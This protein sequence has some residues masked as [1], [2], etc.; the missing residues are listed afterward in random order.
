MFRRI[1]P[2]LL[3]LLMLCVSCGLAEENKAAASG[4]RDADYSRA[5][6]ENYVD[7][8]WK[9]TDPGQQITTVDFRE[10]LSGLISRLALDRLDWF[11]DKVT[12]FQ[13]P[14][15]RGQA[16]T[17]AWYA[18]VCVGA[19]GYTDT[20]HNYSADDPDFWNTEGMSMD[21]LFPE[22]FQPN[23]IMT[24]MSTWDNEFIAS[25]LWNQWHLSPYS[26]KM[27]FDFDKAAVSM[28]NADPCTA[29]EA[30]CAVT[31]LYD[32]A[33]NIQYTFD[34]AAYLERGGNTD[35]E[36]ALLQAADIRRTAIR[37]SRNEI[38][39]TGATYYVSPFG[40]NQNDGKSPENAWATPQYAFSRGLNAGDAVLLERGGEWVVQA[41]GENGST[42]FALLVPEGV[43]VGAYGEGAK[44][45]IRGDIPSESNDPSFWVL[46]DEREGARI[47]KAAHDL[48]DINVIVLN[49]GEV[50]AEKV[51]PCFNGTD[52]CSED[53][54]PFVP[55]NALAEN[56]TFCC[57][58]DLEGNATNVSNR[59]LSGPLYL[60]CDEGNPAEVWE[61]IAVPQCVF[62]V[63]LGKDRTVYDLDIRYFTGGGV[64]MVDEV[65]LQSGTLVNCEISWC[66]GMVAEYQFKNSPIAYAYCGGC[67]VQVTGNNTVVRGCYIHDCGPMAL[68]L[69]I[70]GFDEK[71]KEYR[72][73]NVLLTGN[74][75]ERSGPDHFAEFAKM[76]V[77]GSHGVI[78]NYV[79]EDNMSFFSGMGWITGLI[80][81]CEKGR[82]APGLFRS[83]VEN[84]MGPA[85][86]EGIFIR[87]NVFFCADYT[88]V[89]LGDLLWGG[90]SGT[91]NAQPVFEG[92]TY[93]QQPDLPLLA[94]LDEHRV[95]YPE[96]G[97]TLKALGDSSGTV[98]II[99]AQ[100]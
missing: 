75:I 97:E 13:A 65:G 41:S 6:E 79:F 14:L 46:Y 47:W 35:A 50:W 30:V 55:E 7:S 89:F 3:A 17:M 85:D 99:Q 69:S 20:S 86:N 68:T 45:V 44:P 92:N 83:A 36:R 54:S 26:R 1:M 78:A 25:F 70:H 61:E 58:P 19:D 90:E 18:A 82:V 98:I 59:V 64:R 81:E 84:A 52:Y 23:P 57:L 8:R 95:Y 100:P 87:N 15:V 38:E 91:V 42:S 12:D 73:E 4:K 71:I 53:G 11:H 39:T 60:R 37:E 22:A 28:H 32:S 74:L 72:I 16:V 34:M 31:R 80:D 9:D 2:V 63:S 66:A 43:S 5:F 24:E 21:R 27:T 94:K 76:D 93:V 29:E 96:D 40:N 51:Y 67:A 49:G 48:R 62:A 10:M 77:P 56:L 88:L 33:L